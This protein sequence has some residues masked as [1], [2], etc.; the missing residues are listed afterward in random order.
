MRQRQAV[1]H[2]ATVLAHTMKTGDS[3]GGGS[4][5]DIKEKD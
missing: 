5:P 4:G 1:S 2:G 3:Q